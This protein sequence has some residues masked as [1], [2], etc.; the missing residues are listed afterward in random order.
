MINIL[1]NLGKKEEIPDNA[2]LSDVD[3]NKQVAKIQFK[4]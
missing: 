1:N 4:P 2:L 3:F